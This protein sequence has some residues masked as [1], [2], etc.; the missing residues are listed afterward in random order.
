MIPIYDVK[1]LFQVS[2][3]AKIAR[4]NHLERDVLPEIISIINESNF[5]AANAGE[6]ESTTF[7]NFTARK[8]N[9]DKNKPPLTNMISRTFQDL[10]FKVTIEIHKDGVSFNCRW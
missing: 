7:I 8:V 9:D 4:L 2:T 6:Q 1:T 3:D 10:G 5:D